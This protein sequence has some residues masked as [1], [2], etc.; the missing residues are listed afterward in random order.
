MARV[1]K[2]DDVVAE[3]VIVEGRGR[4]K[5]R[6]NSQNHARHVDLNPAPAN[7]IHPNQ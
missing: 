1:P 7:Q 2:P 6:K 4:S 5:E 3:G